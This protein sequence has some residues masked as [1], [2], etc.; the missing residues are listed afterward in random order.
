MT[1]AATASASPAAATSMR[2]GGG[3]P[4]R[5]ARFTRARAEIGVLEP[6]G[7]KPL[8]E[9]AEL[10]E[11]RAGDEERRAGGLFDGLRL[12]RVK[13]QIANARRNRI[14]RPDMV[15]EQNAE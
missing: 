8:V 7:E 2:R 3:V 15:H 6:H 11:G 9:A 1:G 4:D 12:S 5:Q 13:D 14:G 10:L